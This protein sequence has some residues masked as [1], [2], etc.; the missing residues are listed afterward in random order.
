M[1]KIAEQERENTHG[2]LS[3]QDG[4][5][6]CIGKATASSVRSSHNGDWYGRLIVIL[7]NVD[8]VQVISMS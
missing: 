6:T 2:D 5:R 8:V 1:R 4:H 3:L 7:V